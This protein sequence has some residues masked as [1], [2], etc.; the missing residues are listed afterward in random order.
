MRFAARLFCQALVGKVQRVVGIDWDLRNRSGA[1]DGN[2][3]ET[4]IAGDVDANSNQSGRM[5][6]RQ[7]AVIV[8][9]PRSV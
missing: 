1:G 8:D 5:R 3:K 6:R 4:Y 2:A 9:P 7:T